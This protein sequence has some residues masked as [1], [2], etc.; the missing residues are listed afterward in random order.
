MKFGKKSP[1]RLSKETL[2]WYIELIK[3]FKSFTM[4]DDCIGGREVSSN[5]Y[6]RYDTNSQGNNLKDEIIY[7]L[8]RI[9]CKTLY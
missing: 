7:C 5:L 4:S 1:Q 9:K 6:G 3:S 2:I 8:K